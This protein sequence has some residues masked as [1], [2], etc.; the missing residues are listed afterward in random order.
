MNDS[1]TKKM[2]AGVGFEP[3]AMGSMCAY[4]DDLGI[5]APHKPPSKHI[6]WSH[7]GHKKSNRAVATRPNPCNS[8]DLRGLSVGGYPD[9]WAVVGRSFNNLDYRMPRCGTNK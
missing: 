5:G 9:E 2:V 8:A 7:F 1:I 6:E 3:T 4:V